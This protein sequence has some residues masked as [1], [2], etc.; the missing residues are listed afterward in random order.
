MNVQA[1]T[2]NSV[3]ALGFFDGVHLGHVQLIKRTLELSEKAQSQPIVYTFLN[4]PM[5][6]YAKNDKPR[7]LLSNEE[8][9]E[10]IKVN[11]ISN[12][13]ADNFDEKLCSTPPLDFILELKNRL[14]FKT[15]VVGFNY[16]F[17]KVGAG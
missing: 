7:L 10:A 3:V 15:V 9:F 11:G 14:N 1:N 6:I 13:V 17:G 16:T 2:K 12:I 4:H 8:R 5:S